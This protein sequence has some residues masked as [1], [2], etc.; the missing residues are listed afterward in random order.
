[1]NKKENICECKD[2]PI[3]FCPKCETFYVLDKEGNRTEIAIQVK[4]ASY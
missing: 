3:T 4:K 1:M 2:L